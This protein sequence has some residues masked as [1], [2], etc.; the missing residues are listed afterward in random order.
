MQ[1]FGRLGVKNFVS[2]N[3][4]PA[5]LEDG[6]AEYLLQGANAEG[7][8]EAHCNLKVGQEVQIRGDLSTVLWAYCR[9]C[10]KEVVFK[11]L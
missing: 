6:I 8:I 4:T 7:I 10:P 9:M 1:F 3:D 2:F 11:C 5:P